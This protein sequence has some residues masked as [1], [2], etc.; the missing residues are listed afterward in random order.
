VRGFALRIL[1]ADG[2]GG[3]QDVLMAT[4]KVK[5]P[6][7]TVTFREDLTTARGRVASESRMRV[8]RQR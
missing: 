8:R 3:E 5:A 2:D 6:T 4:D 7:R 1:D